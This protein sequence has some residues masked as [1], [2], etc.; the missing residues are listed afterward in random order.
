MTEPA[1]TDRC[2]VSGITCY[3][4]QTCT[5]VGYSLLTLPLLQFY[6]A[7]ELMDG[8]SPQSKSSNVYTFGE[9]WPAP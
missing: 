1:E 9:L 4:A 7:P 8:C 6:S 2:E 5:W 3:W